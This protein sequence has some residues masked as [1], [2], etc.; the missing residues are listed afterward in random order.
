VE[1]AVNEHQIIIDNGNIIIATGKELMSK[2]DHIIALLP[3]PPP[4]SIINITN[5]GAEKAASADSEAA[6]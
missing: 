6:A 5:T 1:Q 2:A 3:P 4:A